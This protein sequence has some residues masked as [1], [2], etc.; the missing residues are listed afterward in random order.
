MTY[1]ITEVMQS[2]VL[3][4]LLV[5]CVGL[6][7]I[8][9]SRQIRQLHMTICKF[10]LPSRLWSQCTGCYIFCI[11]AGA[12]QFG[13]WEE[14]RS[15]GCSRS[16][17]NSTLSQ[18]CWFYQSSPCLVLLS[19]VE[20]KHRVRWKWR[21]ERKESVC[22]CRNIPPQMCLTYLWQVEV[23]RVALHQKLLGHDIDSEVDLLAL[24]CKGAVPPVQAGDPVPARV[25]RTAEVTVTWGARPA[26]AV[27][28]HRTLSVI[29]VRNTAR[30]NRS[31]LAW[32]AK[33]L[34]NDYW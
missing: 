6:L 15:R 2:F 9:F 27:G 12:A 25:H 26:Q 7:V 11:H 8:S 24:L 30:K 32:H 1:Y 29:V 18:W 14:S 5:Q 10:L 20:V 22:G 19:R 4:R 17:G 3:P 33:K 13:K 34:H 28:I 16:L 23:L 31:L 21:Q